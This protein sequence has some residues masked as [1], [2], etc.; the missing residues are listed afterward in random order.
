MFND[1]LVSNHMRTPACGVAGS[2]DLDAARA[3]MRR[4]EVSCLAVFDRYGRVVGAVSRTDL[5]RAGGAPWLAE[6]HE[7]LVRLPQKAVAEI[8]SAP[9]I[10][11]KPE[12]SLA[13]AAARMVKNRVHRVFVVEHGRAVGVCSTLEIM[14]ALVDAPVTCE[15]REYMSSP[16]VSVVA[17]DPVS[18]ALDRLRDAEIGGVAVLRGDGRPVGVF[19]NVQALAARG[20]SRDTRV[21]ALMDPRA[22]AVQATASIQHAAL[23]A[24]ATSARRVLV[25]DRARLAGLLSS[26]D[27]ARAMAGISSVGEDRHPAP[28]SPSAFA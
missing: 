12:H 2:A 23:Q 13:Q 1:L 14:N 8:M 19:T 21:E 11:V 26:L 10:A 22:I 15:V 24:V 16:V 7:P 18:V 27:F 4:H 20:A 3:L 17:S 9:V 28:I 6:G 25:F 5:L